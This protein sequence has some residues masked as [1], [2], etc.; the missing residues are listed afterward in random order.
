MSQAKSAVYLKPNQ[1]VRRGKNNPK[2]PRWEV[3]QSDTA[4]DAWGVAIR[5]LRKAGKYPQG[6]DHRF[7]QM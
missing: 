7:A 3:H 6:D 5:D 1:R 4:L 2:K